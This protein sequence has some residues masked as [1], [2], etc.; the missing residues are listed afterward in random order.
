[1]ALTA[2]NIAT[3]EWDIAR[4]RVEGDD[5]LKT[6]FSLQHDAPISV[7]DFFAAMTPEDRV[8]TEQKVSEA[9]ANG[10]EFEIEFQI[11]K[12]GRWLVGIGQFLEPDIHGKPTRAV[13]VNIDATDKK[14]QEQH[15]RFMLREINHRVK[16]TLAILQS[17]AAQTLR[18]SHS[19][20]Q[21]M[22]AFSGRLQSI[23]AAH[24]IL[25][26]SEWGSVHLRGMIDVQVRPFA[27][28]VAGA[29]EVI[30]PDIDLEPDEAL[31]LSMILHELATNAHKYGSLTVPTGVVQ[32][33]VSVVNESNLIEVVWEEVNGPKVIPPTARGFGSILIERSLDKV[34]GSKVE[35][36]YADEGFHARITIPAKGRKAENPE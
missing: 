33:T 11:A 10:K 21:F 4:D 35:T 6:M 14:H 17:L 19:A 31:G 32:I 1:M 25:S 5:N 3:W 18:R 30:G 12:T 28:D 22:T 9:L 8:L 34:I 7:R 20:E 23:A 29:V 36:R 2:S 16:N 27:N 13:G 24:T 26:D 15:S